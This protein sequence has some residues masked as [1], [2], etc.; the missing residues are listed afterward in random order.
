MSCTLIDWYHYSVGIFWLRFWGRWWR[1]WLLVGAYQITGRDNTVTIVLLFI[2]TRTSDRQL[3]ICCIYPES[4]VVQCFWYLF[5]KKVH[6]ESGDYIGVYIICEVYA[7]SPFTKL[8]TSDFGDSFIFTIKLEG[9]P[10]VFEDV[11]FSFKLSKTFL[12]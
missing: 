7:D 12:H 2:A 1:Q 6:A 5:Y 3:E 10:Y 8:Y 4:Y 11:S 9:I